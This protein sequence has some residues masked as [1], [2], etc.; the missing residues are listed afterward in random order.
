MGGVRLFLQ[1]P[2][3]RKRGNGHKLEHGKFHKLN[4]TEGTEGGPLQ[5][6]DASES[7]C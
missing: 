5:V 7:V 1:V 2:T 6:Q 4:P 3:D